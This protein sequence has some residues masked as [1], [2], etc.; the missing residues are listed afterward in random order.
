MKEDSVDFNKPQ[1]ILALVAMASGIALVITIL[2]KTSLALMLICLGAFAGFTA[3]FKLS[4]S[5]D[6]ERQFIKHKFKVGL[7]SGFLAT[8]AYDLSRFLLVKL[9]N[10][11]LWPFETFLIFGQ[12]IIGENVPKTAAYVVGT[13]YHFL[14]GVMFSVAY[15]FVLGGRSWQYGILWALFLEAAMF[16]LYPGWLDLEAVMKEFTIVSMIGHITYGV[17]LGFLSRRWLRGRKLDHFLVS[18]QDL[19]LE[20]EQID[21]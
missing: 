17:V 3:A 14:N 18:E 11:N 19:T 8:L 10:M 7:Y 6:R 4:R 21:Q 1:L 20:E 5:R 9:G 12:L 16:T 15:C 2:A 13:A